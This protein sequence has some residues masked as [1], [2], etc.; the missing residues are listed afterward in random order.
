MKKGLVKLSAANATA[1]VPICYRVAG[2]VMKLCGRQEQIILTNN[3]KP[4]EQRL[5]L[6]MHKVITG[7]LGAAWLRMVEKSCR[8]GKVSGSILGYF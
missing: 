2:V 8:G 5:L 3:I 7:A 4:K 1:N 6:G